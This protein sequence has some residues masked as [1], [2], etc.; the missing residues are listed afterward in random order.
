MEIKEPMNYPRKKKALYYYS[1][2]DS[3][4][5]WNSACDEWA[6]AVRKRADIHNIS[7]VTVDLVEK[8]FPKGCC[9]ERGAAIVLHAEMLIAIS[10]HFIEGLNNV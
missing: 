3:T 2:G 10:K 8:N 6:K 1:G 4:K 7:E 5:P 9:K